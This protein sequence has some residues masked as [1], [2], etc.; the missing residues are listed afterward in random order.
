MEITA[1]GKKIGTLQ[2]GVL[3]KTGKQV[4]LFKKYDGFG[5]TRKVLLDERIDQIE[6]HYE[7]KIYKTVPS[8]F[9][10][11]GVPY[12]DNGDQ[13]LILPRKRWTI[14]DPAQTTLV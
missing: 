3:L 10:Y 5:F 6:I 1:F 7:G 13:Q 4:V 8:Q 12:D 14:I 2:N 11:Y 9:F